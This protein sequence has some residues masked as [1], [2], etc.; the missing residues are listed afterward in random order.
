MNDQ[1]IG[2]DEKEMAANSYLMSLL[3]IMV[4]VPLPIVNLI[5][6]FV[7]YLANRKRV[8]FVRWHCMQ[9]LLSQLPLFCI[10]T[11]LFWWT[12][13]LI[14]FDKELSS[15]YFAYL[16]TVLLANFADLVATAITAV[17]VREGQHVEWYVY[18]PL[19]NLLCKNK[20]E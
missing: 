13:G 2:E 8:Y 3:V 14:F 12:I 4:G 11:V 20:A 1:Y 6:T 19:V 16:F 17:K 5:A 10:N 7:F 9:S 18:A 15:I